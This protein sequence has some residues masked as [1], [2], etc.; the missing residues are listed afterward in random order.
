MARKK[1][2]GGRHWHRDSIK[3][4]LLDKIHSPALN[5]S[6]ITAIM[7]CARCK[8]FRGAHLHALLNPITHRHPFELLVGDY[9]SLCQKV[10]V[11]T[12]K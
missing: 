9:L 7:N 12:I 10:K 3:L 5:S 11:D 4:A 8:G 1:H 6:I 2:K